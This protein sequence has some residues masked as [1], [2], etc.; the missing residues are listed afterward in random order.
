MYL[1]LFCERRISVSRACFCCSL[2]IGGL[3]ENLYTFLR[4]PCVYKCKPIANTMWSAELGA[5]LL[6]S[7]RQDVLAWVLLAFGIS[8]G[9]LTRKLYGPRLSSPLYS[10]ACVGA[11][12]WSAS[13]DFAIPLDALLLASVPVCV[14]RWGHGGYAEATHVLGLMMEYVFGRDLRVPREM[15]T[16]PVLAFLC[17]VTGRHPWLRALFVVARH[18]WPRGTRLAYGAV[19]VS[20][21][22]PTVPRMD[23]LF[24]PGLL[25]VGL[26]LLASADWYPAMLA[27]L[28]AVSLVVGI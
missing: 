19:L 26:A 18:V 14:Q 21:D 12:L 1:S 27:A 3:E 23:A 20:L 4:T 25:Y 11:L 22:P 6:V 9:I 13:R 5:V 2:D 28:G 17:V 24:G 10:A 15:W 7:P 8:I 16:P